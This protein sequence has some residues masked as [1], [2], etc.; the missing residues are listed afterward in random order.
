M[1]ERGAAENPQALTTA[2]VCAI[3]LLP[4]PAQATP[5]QPAGAPGP[6]GTETHRETLFAMLP[7]AV[8]DSTTVLGSVLK[9]LCDDLLTRLLPGPREQ[10]LW[11][12]SELLRR[13][14]AEAESLT[15]HILRGAATGNL[16][17]Q[18]VSLIRT[19]V[20]I[21][22][23]NVFAIGS[24]KR[25]ERHSFLNHLAVS[26]DKQKRSAVEAR[27]RRSGLLLHQ[28]LGPGPLETAVFCTQD[29]GNCTLPAALGEKSLHLVLLHPLVLFTT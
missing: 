21:L 3:L 11:M 1:T 25:L 4:P 17:E 5:A 10:V 2:V 15:A 28:Q 20:S 8:P 13:H 14:A 19:L 27:T 7:M 18:N 9:Q 24:H 26:F 16:G 29:S 6:A 23:D 22:T 12:Y